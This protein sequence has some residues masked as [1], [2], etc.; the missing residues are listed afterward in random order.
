MDICGGTGGKEKKG[1]KK[2]VLWLHVVLYKW[3]A[4]KSAPDCVSCGMQLETS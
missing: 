4:A 1:K 2:K 3:Y